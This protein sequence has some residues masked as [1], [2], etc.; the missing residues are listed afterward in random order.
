MTDTI[1]IDII[2]FAL[3][4]ATLDCVRWHESKQ[5]SV[6]IKS[7]MFCAGHSDGHMDACLGEIDLCCILLGDTLTERC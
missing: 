6:E 5:I 7:E 2:D 3:C 4:T 1:I